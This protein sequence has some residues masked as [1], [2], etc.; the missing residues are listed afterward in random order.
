[1]VPLSEW[2]MVDP[3]QDYIKG[4]PMSDEAIGKTGFYELT[5]IT[6]DK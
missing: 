3:Y 2:M 6:I 1:M 5:Y 4:H